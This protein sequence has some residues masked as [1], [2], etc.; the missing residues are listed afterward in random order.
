[1]K[2]PQGFRRRKEGVKMKRLLNKKGSV[3]FLVLVVMS[4][5]IIAA[6]ATYYVVNNQRS[7]VNIRYSSEQSYQTA[8]SVNQTISNYIDGY[9]EYVV[10]DKKGDLSGLEDTIIGKMVNMGIGDTSDITSEIDLSDKGMGKANVTIRK[11]GERDD[12]ENKI[13]VYEITAVAEVN[14]EKV[15]VTQVKEIKTGPTE[16]FTRFLTSTGNRGEDVTFG[17]YMILSDAY[18]ENEFSVIGAS[19][20]TRMTDSLYSSGSLLIGGIQYG[21]PKS[22][23]YE[24]VVAKNLLISDSG[25]NFMSKGG[26]AYV[27]ENFETLND[28]V[29]GVYGAIIGLN[30][31]PLNIYVL[32]DCTLHSGV[33][34][35]GV[36]L[37]VKGDCHITHTDA[38]RTATDIRGKIYVNGNLYID[39]IDPNNFMTSTSELHVK[40]DVIL[41]GTGSMGAKVLEY[42]G[43]LK[44]NGTWGNLD[45]KSPNTSMELPFSDSEIANVAAYVASSTSKNEYQEWDAEGYFDRLEKELNKKG[46]SMPEYHPGPLPAEEAEK[47]KNGMDYNQYSTETEYTINKSGILYPSEGWAG[48]WNAVSL[49]IDATDS[50][51][52]LKLQPL[53]GDDTY[54]FVDRVKSYEPSVDKRRAYL[55][56]LVKG[57]HSVIFILPE[58]KDFVMPGY[59]FIG[60]IGLA[61]KLT[62]VS[63]DQIISNKT[64]IYTD[65]L[66]GSNRGNLNGTTGE[67]DSGA[68]KVIDGWF[69]KSDGTNNIPKDSLVFTNTIIEEK[70]SKYGIHNNIFLVTKGKDNELEFSNNSSLCGYV[71]APSSILRANTTSG[72]G[73]NFVGGMIVGTYT[74]TNLNAALMFTMPCD[75]AN[76]Y[77]LPKKTDIVKELIRIANGGEA[78]PGS[79]G[80]SDKKIQGYGTVGYK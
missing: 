42:G 40:K 52:Y 73:V 11:T 61:S 68:V 66:Y 72:G 12:S 22:G 57:T 31:T 30:T 35:E 39:T 54:S 46:E 18:F 1:M 26:N 60:H 21:I 48:T 3:L 15:T 58:D 2:R 10:H 79:G 74:Y 6:S 38:S 64:K 28:M 47:K 19:A 7:S 67:V 59:T 41:S 49:I 53:E 34:S 16:Y 23:A 45:G 32:G 62:G 29:G 77:K 33:I 5:L 55:N 78:K 75:Y 17:S 51:I 36:S 25:Q 43:E 63:E 9:L 69:A 8:T 44:V 13:H 76:N 71:Y 14:G 50:D 20:A 65:Y 27:G 80:S 70:K 4:L 56:I 37:Y 24:T